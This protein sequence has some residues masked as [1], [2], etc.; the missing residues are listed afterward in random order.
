M[1]G[2]LRDVLV[3]V[4]YN[5]QFHWVIDIVV[6]DISKAYGLVLSRD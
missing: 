3:R 5:P 1:I 6:E 4:V 2:E